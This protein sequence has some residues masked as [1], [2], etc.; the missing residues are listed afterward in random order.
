MLETSTDTRTRLLQAA[1]TLFFQR[2][3]NAV[4]VQ[5]VCALAAVKK[6]SFY[7]FFPS[8]QAL[9]ITAIQNHWLVFKA[10]LERAATLEIPPLERFAFVFSAL[11]QQYAAKL[12]AGQVLTGCPFGSLA[13]EVSAYDVPMREALQSVFSDW[14]DL[15]A[16]FYLEALERGDLPAHSDPQRGARA[17]LAYLEGVLLLVKNSQEPDLLVQLAPS[18]QQ[19]IAFAAPPHTAREEPQ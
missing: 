15:F 1:T 7:H 2:G 10:Q 16:N 14:T 9:V 19:L 11:R 3:Y 17:L 13:L 18:P 5:E 8:K 4:G 12:K 6:G